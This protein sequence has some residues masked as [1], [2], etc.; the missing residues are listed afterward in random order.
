MSSKNILICVLKM[1]EGLTGLSCKGV[2]NFRKRPQKKSW[3][4]KK[5]IS[6][7]FLEMF[8][9]FATLVWND[10]IGRVINNQINFCVSYPFNREKR[11]NESGEEDESGLA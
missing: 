11:T 5:K 6:G 2:E 9:L 7:T 10:M 3:K 8:Q 1:Y 4:V